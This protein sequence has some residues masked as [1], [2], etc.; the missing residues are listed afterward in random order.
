MEKEQLKN[1]PEGLKK[2][3]LK[4]EELAKKLVLMSPYSN[5]NDINKNRL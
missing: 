4:E 3:K 5:R 1:D 2:Q